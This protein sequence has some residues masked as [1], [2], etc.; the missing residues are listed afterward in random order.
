A[1]PEEIEAAT[2]PNMEV[3]VEGQPEA[4]KLEKDA[5]V[6]FT[7]TLVGYTQ[8]PFLLSWNKAKINMEDL[9]EDKAPAKKGPAKK[10]PAKKAASSN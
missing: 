2:A 1:T 8:S 6:R 7:G 3:K 4:K 9:P 5:V 10:A